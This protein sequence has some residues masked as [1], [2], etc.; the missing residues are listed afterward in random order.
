MTIIYSVIVMQVT[1]QLS[2]ASL[3]H[4]SNS[5]GTLEFFTIALFSSSIS[6]L[7]GQVATHALHPMHVSLFIVT[8]INN[9]LILDVCAISFLK[10]VV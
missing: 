2:A 7:S 3:V 8:F 1:G 10:F 4:F 9:H 6:K 5:A